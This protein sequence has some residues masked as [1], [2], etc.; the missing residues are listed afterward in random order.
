ME[1]D[2]AWSPSRLY[3]RSHFLSFFRLSDTCI[4]IIDIELHSRFAALLD[5]NGVLWAEHYNRC[6]L[7]KRL[8]SSLTGGRRVHLRYWAPESHG[9]CWAVGFCM[10]VELI[11]HLW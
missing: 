7:W 8:L 11:Q 6:S 2:E 5:W 1:H 10:P 9:I 4:R 3:Y